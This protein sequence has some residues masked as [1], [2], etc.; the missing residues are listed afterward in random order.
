MKRNL[1]ALAVAG[2]LVV[3][4]AVNA[5]DAAG[6]NVTF[7]G[8]AEVN[9]YNHTIKNS[10]VMP[11]ANDV[12]D[13]QWDSR[14]RVVVTGT[15]GKNAMAAA[16][17]RMQNDSHGDG[18]RGGAGSDLD[19]DYAYLQM[20]IQDLFTIKAGD[21]KRDWGH[22]LYVWDNSAEGISLIKK[23]GDMTFAVHQIMNVEDDGTRVNPKTG[24]T[25]SNDDDTYT[26]I[27]SAEMAKL[28]GLRIDR[29]TD[30]LNDTNLT[31]FD[32][33]GAVPV[34]GWTLAAEYAKRDGGAAKD[35]SGLLLAAIGKMGTVDLTGL[36]ILSMD[37]YTTDNNLLPL[38]FTGDEN[39]VIFT[40]LGAGNT[41]GT[42]KDSSLVGVVAGFEVMPT[43]DLS[44]GAAL[45]NA[46]SNV[47][48]GEEIGITVLHA[49][50]TKNLSKNTAIN[51]QLG[52]F[53][54]DFKA[55]GLGMSA[56][57]AF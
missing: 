18:T 10:N 36:V 16:R 9:Y 25:D 13:D 48:G 42:T 34:A 50:A 35:N 12:K 20:N 51:F 47:A 14:V 3:P 38:N 54:G 7:K 24:L 11:L 44:L 6:P 57:T 1:I 26:I 27:F 23:M 21:W 22:K 37:G 32:L 41:L 2:A 52:N 45:V 43:V 15:D 46:D 49:R 30:D 39:G 56:Y 53:S 31:H 19:F 29:V 4:F 8:D 5:A 28:A 33:Y 17:L 40:G 55:T